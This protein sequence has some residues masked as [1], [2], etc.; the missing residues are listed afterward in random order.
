MHLRAVGQAAGGSHEAKPNLMLTTERERGWL[1]MTSWR[2][3]MAAHGQGQ[4]SGPPLG[5]PRESSDVRCRVDD[6]E[7]SERG[8]IHWNS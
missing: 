8:K 6:L 3:A 5:V 7:D 1:R 4:T 2:E